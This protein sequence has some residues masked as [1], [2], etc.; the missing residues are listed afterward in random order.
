VYL[1]FKELFT[2]NTKNIRKGNMK[3]SKNKTPQPKELTDKSTSVPQISKKYTIY[4]ICV[5]VALAA[6]IFYPPYVRGLYF[7][8]DMFLYH[9]LTA[10]VFLLVLIDKVI[11]KDYEFLSTHLDWAVAAYTGAYL[12]SLIG[13]VVPGEA[14][15]GFLKALNYF[16][17]YWMVSQMVRSYSTYERLVQV[18]VASGVGVA[19]IGILAAT[20]YSK[21]PSAFDGKIIM[22]TLQYK[23]ASAI[24][25]IVMTILG[26]TLWA[27][28]KNK[29]IR[30][31]YSLANY[32]MI[33]V[34]LGTMSKGGWLVLV[35]GAVLLVIGMPGQY[36][37]KASYALIMSGLAAAIATI[38]FLP[39]I[40]GKNASH[41]LPYL[42]LGLS[43]IIGGE[44]LW[45]FLIYAHRR[46]RKAVV[47][48]GVALL[49][50]AFVGTGI[51]GLE[52]GSYIQNKLQSGVVGNQAQKIGNFSDFSYTSRIDIYRWGISM[53]QD[54]PIFGG[55]AGAWKAQYHKYQDYLFYTT[56]VHNHFLQ[57]LIETGLLGLLAFLSM[58]IFMILMI[59]KQRRH[60]IKKKT[61]SVSGSD[62]EHWLLIWGV[63]VAALMAG[64]HACIDFD[65]S[66]GALSI[67]LWTLLALINAGS[68]IEHLYPVKSKNKWVLLIMGL[69]LFIVLMASGQRMMTANNLYKNAS[70]LL[71]QAMKKEDGA[72]KEALLNQAATMV[73]KAGH[74]DPCNVYYPAMLAQT[75]ASEYQLLIQQKSSGSSEKL[76]AVNEAMKTAEKLKPFD[77]EARNA[78]F[79]TSIMIQDI[80][81]AI[82]Q[83]QLQIEMNPL[84][85]DAYSAVIRLDVIAAETSLNQKDNK[86]AVKYLQTAIR[87]EAKMESQKS[88]IDPQKMQ[89]PFWSG[90]P[91]VLSQDAQ[92]N[93][94]EA[95][96]L[97]GDY[98]RA[99]QV[100]QPLI[101]VQMDAAFPVKAWYFAA[102]NKNGASVETQAEIKTW[103]AS[104][105][106]GAITFYSLL[107]MTPFTK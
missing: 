39:A 80:P 92:F 68:H 95:Y 74:T 93:L 67:M 51:V 103:Q 65:L 71:N 27:K 29:F 26:T 24:F 19:L 30:P 23:N 36:R 31:L 98:L 21:Y 91:F 97:M 56:E 63:T 13:A 3:V 86:A 58:W 106:E 55:G 83:A 75:T 100:L 1:S 89:V 43:V 20:G 15:Y 33:L 9:I 14:V 25:L 87:C 37:F 32:L 81:G 77:E 53:A 48:S 70:S 41:A 46:W 84:Y 18:L 34:I 107:N 94:G 60:L 102:L 4:T 35:L 12:L 54:H 85:A 78:M 104:D 72:Q 52:H 73:A 2:T 45:Y 16:M 62:L 105:P 11:R 99:Q 50:I 66:L 96:Y 57:V 17:V 90:K 47:I 6:L 10:L 38:K 8:E 44:L 76:Q 101:D 22:S 42:L 28:E 82:Q 69:I 59:V 61:G 88:K 49:L 7:S 5:F 64:V 79:N 40:A